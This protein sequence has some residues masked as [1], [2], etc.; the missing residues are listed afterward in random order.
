[1]KHFIPSNVCV[2]GGG[3]LG[4]RS[5]CN[6]GGLPGWSTLRVAT[7]DKGDPRITHFYIIKF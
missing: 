6:M 1:M 7:G 3:C 4:E 5:H 2:C